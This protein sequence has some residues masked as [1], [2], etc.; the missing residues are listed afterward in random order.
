MF[1]LKTWLKEQGLSARE[2]AGLLEVSRKTVEDWVYE[3]AVP[4]ERNLDALNNFIA[5]A[6]SHHWVIEASNGPMSEGE[7]QRCGESR[8]FCNS[9][10]S[11]WFHPARWTLDL[12]ES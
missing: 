6:C 10:E 12:K 3:G 4:K 2:L 7:C 8:E 1:E 9:P 11:S 5:A